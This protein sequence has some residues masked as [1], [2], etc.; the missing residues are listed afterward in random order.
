MWAVTRLHRHLDT[1]LGAL[2]VAAILVAATATA[3]ADR[4]EDFARTLERD[5]DEKARIAAAVGLGR[6]EDPRGVPALIRA[7]ENDKS[8]VVRG[9]AASALGKIGDPRAIPAL[10]RALN[11]PSHA[12]RERA[13]DALTAIRARD[14]RSNG[15]ATRVIDRRADHVTPKE[16]P[17]LDR[18]P[19]APPA[20]IYVVVKSTVNRAGGSKVLATKLRQFLVRELEASPEVTMDAEIARDRR[21]THFVIDAEIV[22]LKRSQTGPWIELVCE[23]RVT[24]SNDAGRMMS[25]VTGAATLQIPRNEYT[26]RAENAL[27]VTALDNA[28]QGAHQNLLGFM[29]R[30]VAQR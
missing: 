27:Q 21:L 10:E 7:V 24:I 6:L 22:R 9:V 29:A 18:G 5:P 11:D 2:L 23:V 3:W 13:R 8:A 1:S 20:K 14:A 19:N 28:V 16:P 25:I 30:Q 4:L 17:R 26:P 12:V 15:A